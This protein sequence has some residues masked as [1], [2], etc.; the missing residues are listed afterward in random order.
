M[1]LFWGNL[2]LSTALLVAFGAPQAAVAGLS[3]KSGGHEIGLGLVSRFRYECWD[4][5]ASDPR[6]FSAV[7]SRASL[8]YSYE[9][10]VT[11][12]AE[13]QDARLNGLESDGSGAGDLYFDFSRVSSKT[14]D[15]D[16]RQVWLQVKLAEGLRVRAGRQDF[17]LA[18]EVMYPEGN[19]KYLK[20]ARLSQRLVGTVG[21]THGER[22]NDALSATY[23]LGEHHLFLWGGKPT[24]GVF[25]VDRAYDTQDDIKYGG[26]Q[27][28]AKRGAWIDDTE[29]R[30]FGIGYFDE[31]PPSDGGLSLNKEVRVYT[32]GAS[33]LGVK[34]MGSGN[35]DYLLWGAWQWGDFPDRF[36]AAPITG[37][38]SQRAWAFLAE[39][40]YQLPEVAWKP[41]MRVGVNMASGD[42]DPNDSDHETFFNILPTNHLYYGFQDRFALSNL[43]DYF[44][45]LKLAPTGKLGANLFLHHFVAMEKEDARVFGTGAF[46]KK[47]NFGYGYDGSALGHASMGT[48]VDLVL[49]YKLHQYLGLQA[50]YTYMWGHARFNGMADDDV[51]FGY[52]QVTAKY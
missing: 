25:D 39:F 31:R 13:F 51:R 22:S 47:G 30:I 8:K 26:F 10:F 1:R 5:H 23:E 4:A 50:G 43:I 32:A 45:Q 24:T 49:D 14:S 20:G 19:W 37:D 29:F 18:T 36:M 16:L 11:A 46:T 44:A 27:M 6:C 12:F 28:T 35:F 40:G 33:M 2:A 38:L 17:K 3:W 7:R 34:K 52:L 48:A 15:Q 21:W 9:D 41:W 42:D